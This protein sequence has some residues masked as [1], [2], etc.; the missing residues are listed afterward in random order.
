MPLFAGL[1]QLL[2]GGLTSFLS[3]FFVEAVARRIAL[4]TLITAGSA[5]LM[6]TLGA[7]L[8]SISY[9]SILTTGF[10]LVNGAALS[11]FIGVVVA[12][13]AAVTAHNFSVRIGK[14]AAGG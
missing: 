2:L 13:E 3:V 4:I 14:A 1:F 9:P 8:P 7:L 12:T 5:A 6:A 10:Y 11:I